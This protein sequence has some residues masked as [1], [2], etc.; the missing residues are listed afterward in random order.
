MQNAWKNAE[1]GVMFM[2]QFSNYNLMQYVD[3]YQIY[4]S[5]PCGF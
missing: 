5:N 1:P 4:T 3:D 2:N